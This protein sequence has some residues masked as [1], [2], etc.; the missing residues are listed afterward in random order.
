MHQK[1]TDADMLEKTFSTF[2]ASNMLLQQQYREKGFKQYFEL[3]SCLLVVEQNNELLMKNHES[4]LTEIIPF[5]EMNVVNF[6][7]RGRRHDRGRGRNNYYF[8]GG[9]SNH[10]NFKRTTQNN[11]HKEKTPQDKNSKG[12]EHKCF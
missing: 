8:C 11:D 7:N 1:I 10:P 6:N 5:P 9:R 12:D 2:H 4:R 3:I